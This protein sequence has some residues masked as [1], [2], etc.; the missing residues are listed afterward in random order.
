MADQICFKIFFG[1]RM[2]LVPL[3]LVVSASSSVAKYDEKFVA[4]EPRRSEAM[5][6]ALVS[7]HASK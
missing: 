5:L 4:G 6:I 2:V 1:P 7:G 3:Y